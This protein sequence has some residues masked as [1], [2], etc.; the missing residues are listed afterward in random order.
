[1]RM[2]VTLQQSDQ[3]VVC[4]ICPT[5]LGRQCNGGLQQSADFIVGKEVGSAPLVAIRQKI[6]GRHLRARIKRRA[7]T[8]KAAYEG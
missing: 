4:M 5:V 2:P 3:A 1:M 6:S 7:V 8:G